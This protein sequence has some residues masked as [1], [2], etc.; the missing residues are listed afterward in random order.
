MGRK[1]FANCKVPGRPVNAK[2][3]WSVSMAQAAGEAVER[4]W[5]GALRPLC[6]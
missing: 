2:V 6:P 1:P 5:R 3:K 4:G